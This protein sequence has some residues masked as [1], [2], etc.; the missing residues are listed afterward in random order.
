MI[1]KNSFL[2]HVNN[3]RELNL[4]QIHKRDAI[5]SEIQNL[6]V[7]IQKT[8]DP[9]ERV[10]LKKSR[11]IL[12]RQLNGVISMHEFDLKMVPFMKDCYSTSQ[13]S[14]EDLQK[15][16]D[17]E[18]NITEQEVSYMAAEVD[19]CTRCNIK[20]VQIPSEAK[21][22][23]VKC[24]ISKFYLDTSMLTM[25]YGDEIE[26]SSFSYRRIG[27]FKEL[28]NYLQAKETTHVQVH[29]LKKV[30]Q[31]LVRM[32][33]HKV[34]QITFQEV[35]KALR[36][37]GM[38]K[39][40]DHTMQIYCLITGNEPLRLEAQLEEKFMLM[41]KA[42]QQPWERHKLHC[43]EERKN[44]LSYPYCFYKIS[45]LLGR[46]DLLDY[47]TL[48]KCPKKRRDQEHVFFM[49]CQDLH[50]PFIPAN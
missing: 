27:H 41:F 38:R 42:I 26:Y 20:Y 2:E 17:V 47:F 34:D 18:F 1:S 16:F 33:I 46:N 21:L 39:Y 48:L 49:I 3:Q 9:H 7:R 13:I 36:S 30:M 8:S 32:E 40:Y 44:F 28:L 23:C 35:R 50:W 15:E 11:L 22:V 19:I 4:K 45:Q 29:I 12:I 24:G 5:D 31:Q 43:R 37:L 6:S 25:A 10:A 14:T